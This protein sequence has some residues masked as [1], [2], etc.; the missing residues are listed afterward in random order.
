MGRLNIQVTV[1]LKVTVTL[2]AE[3]KKQLDGL[4]YE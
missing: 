3:I 1:T 4:K 2:R